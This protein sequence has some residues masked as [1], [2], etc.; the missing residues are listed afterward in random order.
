[1]HRTT[2]AVIDELE[3]LGRSPSTISAYSKAVED[4]SYHHRK[5]PS[6]LI[7]KDAHAYLCHLFR[8]KKVSGSVYHLHLC[9]LRFLYKEV[10]ELKPD[11]GK[12]PKHKKGKTLPVVF[13]LGEVGRVI[14]SVDNLKHQTLIAT[15][16]AGGLRVSEVCRLQVP[17]IDS[18]LMRIRIRNGKGC[19]DRYVML[20]ESLLPRLRTYYRA[21]RPKLWLFPSAAGDK[22]LDIRTAQRVFTTAKNKAGIQKPVSFHT[23]RHSFATHLLETGADLR[24]IQEL[25]GHASIRT[26]QMYT[27]VT[28]TGATSIRSPL[29]YVPLS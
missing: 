24:Y 26:T 23:L 25:L 21:Y 18:E 6:D 8:V 2:Y 29:D 28:T 16:Y 10:L 14:E 17:D 27:K 20:S 12:I 22:P 15:A 13:S 1:M 19:K 3:S 11:F 7:G 9:A 4:F 5:A